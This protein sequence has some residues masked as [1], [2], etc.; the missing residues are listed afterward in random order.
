M[1][2]WKWLWK[3]RGAM[4]ND[5]EGAMRGTRQNKVR[6]H[7]YDSNSMQTARPH[8]S[9]HDAT[10]PHTTALPF[11]ISRRTDFISRS[12]GAGAV[13]GDHVPIPLYFDHL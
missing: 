2:V 7:D 13:L 1:S 10:K 8:R 5:D 4:C 11:S 3:M 9:L 12:M 6:F